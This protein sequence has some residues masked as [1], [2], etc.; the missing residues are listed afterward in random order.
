MEILDVDDQN[1]HTA[2]WPDCTA[3]RD[4]TAIGFSLEPIMDDEDGGERTNAEYY[5]S[6]WTKSITVRLSAKRV[7]PKRSTKRFAKD[8]DKANPMVCRNQD[9]NH[10]RKFQLCLA[11]H[12]QTRVKPKAKA[13]GL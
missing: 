7:K 3:S 2:R 6:L 4:P 13:S 8:G 11:K 1:R 5:A 10:T 9:R 12:R